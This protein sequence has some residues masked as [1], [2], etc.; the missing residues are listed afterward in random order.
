M[1]MLEAIDNAEA[2][3]EQIAQELDAMPQH[4]DEE[5]LHGDADKLL[6]EALRLSGARK[7]ADAF[8]RAQERVGFWYA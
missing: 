2:R 7:V 5:I 8:E 1:H 3:V 4:G 6:C